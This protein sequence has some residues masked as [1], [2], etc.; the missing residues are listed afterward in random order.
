MN[1]TQRM[2]KTDTICI[3]LTDAE[4]TNAKIV[5]Y[6]TQECVILLEHCLALASR[7]SFVIS[8][9]LLDHIMKLIHKSMGDIE[10]VPAETLTV[11]LVSWP[12]GLGWVQHSFL[13]WDEPS[14][15]WLRDL[16]LRK[17]EESLVKNSPSLHC[18]YF[19]W[20]TKKELASKPLHLFC[21]RIYV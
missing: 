7:A 4:E 2:L 14:C 18:A 15:V 17:Q 10:N 3:V 20:C 16:Q 6:S 8:W 19:V 11:C 21:I 13:G 5:R 1:D 12:S 9:I